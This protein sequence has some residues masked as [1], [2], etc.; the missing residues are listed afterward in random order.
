MSYSNLL[1]RNTQFVLLPFGGQMGKQ[2]FGSP[3]GLFG[4]VCVQNIAKF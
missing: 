3:D 1:F 2:Y 4:T